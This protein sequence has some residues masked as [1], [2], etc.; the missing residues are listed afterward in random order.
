MI[1]QLLGDAL[2]QS[3]QELRYFKSFPDRLIALKV[4]FQGLFYL[5]ILGLILFWFSITVYIGIVSSFWSAFAL[6][7]CI[8]FRCIVRNIVRCQI[9]ISQ[10]FRHIPFDI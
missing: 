6:F 2:H 4:G 8:L 7:A 10:G 5:F 9:L 3:I 1:Q